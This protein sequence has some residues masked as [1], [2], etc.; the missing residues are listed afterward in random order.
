MPPIAAGQ[1][2]QP[3]LPSGL[4][5][6]S[7]GEP[8]PASCGDSAGSSSPFGPHRHRRYALCACTRLRA[9]PPPDL[10]PRP[11]RR[12]VGER[13]R[14]SSPSRS[15]RPDCAPLPSSRRCPSGWVGVLAFP[16]PVRAPSLALGGWPGRSLSPVFR[17]S[18]AACPLSPHKEIFTFDQDLSSH[19]AVTVPRRWSL[20]SLQTTLR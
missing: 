17:R 7:G 8:R 10:P 9:H 16:R 4:S 6:S 14:L 19:L 1:A 2:R 5:P 11:L 12:H 15:C 18:P 13:G 20:L 3:P